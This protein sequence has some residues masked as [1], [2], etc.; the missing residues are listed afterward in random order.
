[1]PTIQGLRRRGF[2][3]AS[4]RD[5]AERGGVTKKENQIELALL[6]NCIREDLDR[7][8]LRAMAVLRPLRVVIDNYPEGQVEELEIPNHPARPE[9]GTRK[10]PFSRVILIEQEDFMENPPPKYFRLQPGKEVR[11]RSAYWIKCE[12]VVKDAAGRVTEVH[13]TYDPQTR[14]GHNPPD[15]RKVKGTLHWVSEAHAV[16]AEVRLYDRLFSA[17][18]PGQG[19]VDP[20]TQLN[21]G[22]L[23]TL[24]DC[25]LE[26]QL[27]KA[28]PE[29]RWQFERLGYFCADRYDMKPG[30]AVFNRTVTLR[31]SWAK[32]SGS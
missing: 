23:E 20:I 13:A 11:L 12:R 9:L 7:N 5:F 16:K 10:I 32:E 24:T 4:L 22:S 30:A 21:P 1:M 29:S 3:P 31:D 25:R 26:P 2:T 8:A 15:G 17:R 19:G 18:H 14:G 27:A 28:E 6:E